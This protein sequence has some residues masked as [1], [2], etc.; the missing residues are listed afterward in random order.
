MKAHWS[1]ADYRAMMISHPLPFAP[2]DIRL[3]RAHFGMTVE[4]QAGAVR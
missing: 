1:F 2:E 3:V 4:E